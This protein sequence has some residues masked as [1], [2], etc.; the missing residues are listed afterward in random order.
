MSTSVSL[1]GFIRNTRLELP[2][3]LLSSRRT[4]RR[5]FIL[6]SPSPLPSDTRIR[7]KEKVSTPSS[8]YYTLSDREK[9]QI[10]SDLAYFWCSVIIWL[11]PYLHR[12][13]RYFGDRKELKNA[14][15]TI[16]RYFD[17]DV[18]KQHNTTQHNTTNYTV[19]KKSAKWRKQ[20]DLKYVFLIYMYFPIHHCFFW[21][22]RL[23][24]IVIVKWWWWGWW[25][26]WWMVMNG[27][28]G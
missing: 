2:L 1:S 6:S 23:V 4:N 18:V 24:F 19:E 20:I 21:T 12:S 25:W 17:L 8:V 10:V 27:D 13:E 16:L 28:D 11:R 5:Y 7:N 3:V 22:T 14:F 9:H 26:W 15:A